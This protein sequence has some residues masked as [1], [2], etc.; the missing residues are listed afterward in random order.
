MLELLTQPGYQR[1]VHEQ[2]FLR[3]RYHILR[4]RPLRRLL[5]LTPWL[6]RLLI[7]QFE[8]RLSRSTFL[9]LLLK[10]VTL[11]PPAL[12]KLETKLFAQPHDLFLAIDLILPYILLH[13]AQLVEGKILSGVYH[14]IFLL[15]FLLVCAFDAL[16]FLNHLGNLGLQGGDLASL[17]LTEARYRQAFFL[18]GLE[19]GAQGFVLGL[20]S[21]VLLQQI[22]VLLSF[23]IC[24]E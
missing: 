23:N 13:L 1:R 20:Q 22:Q 6:P 12:L 3:F 18:L 8:P 15:Q 19:T 14:V 21:L 11:W 4:G 17:D 5:G 7:A 9:F 2:V 10:S 24:F 16:Q